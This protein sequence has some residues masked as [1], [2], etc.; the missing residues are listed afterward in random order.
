MAQPIFGFASD[1]PLDLL[2]NAIAVTGF[3]GKL[4]EVMA[5][6]PDRQLSDNETHGF[7]LVLIALENT[8]KEAHRKM[9]Q[10]Q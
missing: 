7:N 10:Q 9:E 6:D 1:N 2:S 4:T 8:I 3:L 5:Y